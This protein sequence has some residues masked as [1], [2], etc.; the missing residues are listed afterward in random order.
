MKDVDNN[1]ITNKVNT[2]TSMPKR[3]CKILIKH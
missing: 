1:D 2:K 3:I